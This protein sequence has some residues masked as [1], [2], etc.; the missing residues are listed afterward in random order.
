MPVFF[1]DIAGNQNRGRV[2][3]LTR[4][5]AGEASLVHVPGWAGFPVL[6]SIFTNITLAE[7]G[8]Y[9]FQHMLGNHIYS[10]VFGDR[11]GAFGLSGLS[12]YDNCVSGGLN[13]RIGI[14]H[15]IQY[16][17]RFRIT[18]NSEPL[19]ITIQPDT[20]FQCFLLSMRGQVLNAAQRLFQFHLN[21]ALV[22]D[23]RFA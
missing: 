20:V 8:N 19:L 14:L 10:Y 3:V 4:P 6:K 18:A 22:P 5:G 13:G 15:V 23:N 12:F 9:Q 11:I 21:L 17:R 1:T 7:Q 16:Y 2:Q